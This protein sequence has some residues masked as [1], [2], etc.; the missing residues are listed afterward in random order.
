MPLFLSTRYHSE[1]LDPSN[2]P[3]QEHFPSLALAR[4]WQLTNIV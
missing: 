1:N 3:Y 4:N 2:L